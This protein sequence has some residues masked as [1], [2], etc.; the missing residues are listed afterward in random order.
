MTPENIVHKIISIPIPKRSIH[1]KIAW[2]YAS[3]KNSQS[4]QTHTLIMFLFLL[5][6]GLKSLIISGNSIPFVEQKCFNL[7]GRKF[8]PELI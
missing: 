7:L 6:L 5:T 1:D 8:A 3:T 2:K 4:V